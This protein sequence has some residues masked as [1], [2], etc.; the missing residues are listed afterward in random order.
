MVAIDH[1]YELGYGDTEINFLHRGEGVADES[2][3]STILTVSAVEEENSEVAE[4]LRRAGA[5]NVHTIQ[6]ADR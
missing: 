3:P 1:L 2:S 5:S 4:T 6:A